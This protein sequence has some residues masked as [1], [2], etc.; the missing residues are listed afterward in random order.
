MRNMENIESRDSRAF[1]KI[2]FRERGSLS[3]RRFKQ[4]FSYFSLL[5]VCAAA[6]AVSCTPETIE[7]P[8]KNDSGDIGEKVDSAV[9]MFSV[10]SKH[11]IRSL[12]LLIFEDNENGR[13]IHHSFQ[14]G[15]NLGNTE[16]RL[17]VGSKRIAAIANSPK[18][19]NDKALSSYSSINL[20]SYSFEDD[21]QDHPIMGA[22]GSGKDISLS[23]EPLL[24]RIIISQI[25]NNMENYELFESPKA[26]LSNINAS[27]ELFGKTKYYPSETVSSKEWMDFPYDIGMYAQTPNIEMTCYP[28]DTEYESFGPDMTS[29]EIQGIIKGER[30]TFTFPVKSIP[31]GSTVFASVSINS[32]TNASCD[33]KTSPPGRD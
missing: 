26:R 31:R 1:T 24:C 7:W 3:P 19:L 32:E 11:P 28:N 10:E 18:K 8:P 21:D 30:R 2:R 6:P 15:E 12:D 4:I 22:T 9:F 5:L 29:L 27:A 14:K 23:L 25:A 13:L 16:L 17:P 33:F 20:I